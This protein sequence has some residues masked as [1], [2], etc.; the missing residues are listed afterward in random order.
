[1]TIKEWPES[2][3]P[4]EKLLR[5]GAGSLSDAELL[6]IFLRTGVRGKSAVDVSRDLISEFG[7]LRGVLTANQDVFCRI[8]G[9]GPVKFLHMQAALELGKRFL[10]LKIRR[11]DVMTDPDS[12]NDFLSLNLR[13]RSREVFAV[14]FLDNRHQV[15]EYEEMFK[16]TLDSAP[17]HPREIVKK[18]LHHNAAAI[19]IAHNHPSGV[20]EPSQS[21]ADITIKI[22]KALQLIN[23][24]LLDHI[25]VGDGEFV[26]LS[27]RGII[28]GG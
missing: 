18:V 24:R 10:A 1:M 12:V 7:D 3:R 16:G 21:D 28:R 11:R 26:S 9:L 6:A 5:R 27:N 25:I 23:V 20:A 19:I 4:R 14:L 8:P 15:I 17:V 13:D 2:E 22:Q